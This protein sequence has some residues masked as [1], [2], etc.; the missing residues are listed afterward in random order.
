[1]KKSEVKNLAVW[2]DGL[3]SGWKRM[4]G[5]VFVI[6]AMYVLPDNTK[7]IAA[8]FGFFMASFGFAAK[9]MSKKL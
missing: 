4:I 8:A 3:I 1:M 5:L 2:F 9:Q 7:D 6:L